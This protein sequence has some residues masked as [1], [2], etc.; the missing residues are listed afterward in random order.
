MIR[1][2]FFDC[3]GVLYVDVSEAY[4]A[5]FPELYEEL[6]DLNK[7]ADHGFMDRQTYIESVARITGISAAE[8]ATAFSQEHVLNRP[9]ID[10]I[11]HELKP[12]YKIGLLTNIG[13][14]WIQDFFDEHQLHG[15]FDEVL[16]SSEQGITKPNP[17]L[18][19]RAA[20]HAGFP[21]GECVM[22]DD[23][24]ENCDG[25]E[26]AGMKSVLYRSNHE[27]MGSLS[28]LDKGAF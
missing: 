17:L 4:F 20:E 6:H 10:Y 25:A 12:K 19:E 3:F 15:L 8:T 26:Q 23:R 9:L 16:L 7:Q 13:R 24:Q 14:G 11:Q 21:P 1:A 2:L 5:K 18:F 28:Q 22:I 27:L